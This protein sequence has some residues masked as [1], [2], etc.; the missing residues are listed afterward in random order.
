[1][2]KPFVVFVL[3]GPGSGKG[4]QCSNIVKHF[5]FVHLSAGDLLREEM[6][7]GSELA[8][9]IAD[10]MKDGKIVPSEVTVGLLDT[11]MKKSGKNKFLIDGFPRNEE[12]NS[13][14]EKQMADKVELQFILF[15]DCPEEIMQ[16]RILKRG[17]SSGRNDDNPET[18]KKRFNTH[19]N[20]TIP[21]VNSYD[22][23]G[24]VVKI[25]ANRSVEEVWEDV[26]GNFQKYNF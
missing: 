13:S 16:E 17:K 14:W 19:I 25:D 2:S 15:F 11:A 23:R 26:K 7:S 20:E 4:T 18:I 24:K 9:M 10:F 3:G 1:M 21:V 22:Q 12:N 5:N 6:A 8:G